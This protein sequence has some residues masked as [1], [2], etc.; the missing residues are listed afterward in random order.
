MLPSR[1]ASW[2]AFLADVRAALEDPATHFFAD[3]SFLLK[4]ASL[5]VPAR[6]VVL[7][8][9]DG[10]G[11]DRFHI[12]AWVGHETYRHLGKDN[13]AALTPMA[14]LAAELTAKLEELRMEARRFV[15][16]DV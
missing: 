15:D 2:S 3:T 4:A 5:N 11:P 6:T 14:K 13:G 8:W 9:I 1:R 12:P 10:I 7:A 16:D